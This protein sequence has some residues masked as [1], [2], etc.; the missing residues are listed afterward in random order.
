ME[1][2]QRRSF[3][4]DYK[5]HCPRKKTWSMGACGLESGDVVPTAIP[6]RKMTN[7]HNPDPPTHDWTEDSQCPRRQPKTARN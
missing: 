6:I 1:G 4:D 3:T 5:R 7:W 2:R